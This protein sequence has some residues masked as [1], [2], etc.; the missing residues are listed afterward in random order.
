MRMF[1]SSIE[2]IIYTHYWKVNNR[3]VAYVWSICFKGKSVERVLKTA[4]ASVGETK[5][6][7]LNYRRSNILKYNI[8]TGTF[9]PF[10]R[11]RCFCNNVIWLNRK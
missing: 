6:P 4:I 1:K 7:D 8:C 10:I 3:S 9:F 2:F 5:N 11:I